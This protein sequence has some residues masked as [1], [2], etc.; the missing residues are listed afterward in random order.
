MREKSTVLNDVADVMADVHYRAGAKWPIGDQ[1]FAGIR[2]HQSDDEAQ[3]GGFSAAT[4]ANENRGPTALDVE[5]DVGERVLGAKTFA[6]S[7]KLDQGT[8][9]RSG[10]SS[11]CETAASQS[12]ALQSSR[13]IVH[14][15]KKNAEQLRFVGP[16]FFKLQT[17]AISH[18]D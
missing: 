12:S 14:D 18:R 9:V 11:S 6:D 15:K 3:R 1:D 16:H 5:V 4:G 13:L 8:H 2:L 10:G 7:V 17:G